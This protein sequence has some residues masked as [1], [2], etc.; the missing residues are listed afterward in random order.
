[1]LTLPSDATHV[2]IGQLTK[3]FKT[4][5]IK[6]R[7]YWMVYSQTLQKWVKLYSWEN[8]GHLTSPNV[9]EGHVFIPI[10]EAQEYLFKAGITTMPP[11]TNTIMVTE[12]DLRR[13][14]FEA[15]K[16]GYVQKMN[17]PFDNDFLRLAHE[18]AS[19]EA[20]KCIPF[21]D[22]LVRSVDDRNLRTNLERL[23][24]EIE[25]KTEIHKMQSS[26]QS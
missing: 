7:T 5:V 1:M 16:V 18:E 24:A 10:S 17:I 19:I 23:N 4:Q 3:F 6:N 26:T 2:H 21:F 22:S 13:V 14:L 9:R 25:V 12:Q 20:S 8:L 15:F 11:K